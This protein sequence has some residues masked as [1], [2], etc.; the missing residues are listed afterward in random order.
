M[1]EVTAKAVI[2][3]QQVGIE[4][5]VRQTMSNIDP[6]A[7]EAQLLELGAVFLALAPAGMQIKNVVKTDTTTYQ[8]T[9]EGTEEV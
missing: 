1:A 6:T 3:L 7:T 5:A 8:P 2:S 9:I 4:E